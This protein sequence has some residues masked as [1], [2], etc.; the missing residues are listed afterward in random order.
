MIRATTRMIPLIWPQSYRRAQ[1]NLAGEERFI[2]VC[3]ADRSKKLVRPINLTSHQ[4]L[5]VTAVDDP[6]DA[7][8][9][10]RSISANT[11]QPKYSRV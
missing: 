8:T 9:H 1:R 10:H 5:R 7:P 6:P 3:Y 11:P 4:L 2:P